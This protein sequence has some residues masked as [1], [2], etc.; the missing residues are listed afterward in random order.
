MVIGTDRKFS[1]T[2]LENAALN[3]GKVLK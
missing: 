1:Q 3:I 2:T